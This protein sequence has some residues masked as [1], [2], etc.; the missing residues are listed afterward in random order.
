[1]HAAQ[2]ARG[3][4][5]CGSPR[6]SVDHRIVG[7]P[8]R[9]VQE[10]LGVEERTTRLPELA[11]HGAY[12]HVGRPGA[13]GMAAHAVHDDEECRPVA[14]GDGDSILVFFAIPEEAQ[15]RVLDMQ[16]SLRHACFS[17]RLVLLL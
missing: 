10:S 1:M 15:I 4:I 3:R 16:V 17:C 5:S 11:D 7:P 8:D 9:Q 12:R 13:V 14:D 2:V 6:P